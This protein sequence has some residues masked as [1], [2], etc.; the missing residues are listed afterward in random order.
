MLES[1]RL[2][3]GQQQSPQRLAQELSGFGYRRVEAVAEGAESTLKAFLERIAR[4]PMRPYIRKTDVEWG[5]ATG[6]FEDFGIRF[7]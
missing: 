2:Y 7:I 3:V 6:E 5:K 1:I 4:G